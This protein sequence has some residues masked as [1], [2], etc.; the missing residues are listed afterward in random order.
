MGYDLDTWRKRVA[1]RTD[2]SSQV[3]HL[4]RAAE[5]KKISEVLFDIVN[6]KKLKGS[7]T[8]SGFI[9]GSRTAVCFQDAPLVSICQNVFYEQ[10]YKK[11]NP[12][13]KDRYRAVGIAFTKP[14]VYK[15]GG[16]P[17]IYDKTSEAKKYIQKSEWWRIVNYDLTDPTAFVDWT[18]EREWRVPDDMEFSLE[19]ATLL[20]VNSGIY[21]EF[22]KICK[23]N[24]SNCLDEV[25]GI[26]VMD[27]LLY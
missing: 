27:N 24:R 20:F 2:I 21:R 11:A 8:K 17:V 23:K 19:E 3:V 13:S 5:G 7:S 18:H 4:T 9:C 6:G 15:K 10:K 25:K 16:R 22:E 1:E 26:V 14:F 12:E